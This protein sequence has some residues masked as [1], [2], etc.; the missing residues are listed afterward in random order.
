MGIRYFFLYF[1]ITLGTL[2]KIPYLNNTS[3]P[4]LR[5]KY[6]ISLSSLMLGEGKENTMDS[7]PM[8]GISNS[9]FSFMDSFFFEDH[10]TSGSNHFFSSNA[11]Y[12]SLKWVDLGMVL[13]NSTVSPSFCGILYYFQ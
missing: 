13:G 10:H 1:W 2:E 11:V 12:H 9:H 4:P 8:E 7:I 6:T 5:G 3:P